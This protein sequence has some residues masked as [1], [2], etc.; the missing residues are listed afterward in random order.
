[1]K[2]GRRNDIKCDDNYIHKNHEG[3]SCVMI[4]RKKLVVQS[5]PILF[6]EI[7]VDALSFLLF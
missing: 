2:K 5:F 6:H 4:T 3:Y 1:M 7:S